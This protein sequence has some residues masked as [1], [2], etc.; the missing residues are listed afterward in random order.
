MNIHPVNGQH[1]NGRV[2]YQEKS[3]T[4]YKDEFNDKTYLH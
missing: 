2:H 3:K 1:P 4:I